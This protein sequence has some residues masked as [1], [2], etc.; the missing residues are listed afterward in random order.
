MIISLNA[1]SKS[2]D[3]RIVDDTGLPVTGLVAATFPTLT[4]SRAGA[5]ADVAFPALSDLALI[6]T[7]YASGGVKERGVGVYRLDVPNAMFTTQGQI[8]IR[9]EATNK[10][11]M[12]PVLDVG[13]IATT[14]VTPTTSQTTDRVVASTITCY[15]DENGWSIGPIITLDDAGD[16]VDLTTFTSLLFTVEDQ[17]ETDLLSTASV[18][19]SGA[20]DNQWTVTGTS[21]ITASAPAT[22]NWSL[23]GIS[24]G[25]NQVLGLG[26]LIV[27]VAASAD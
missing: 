11:V 15:L 7:A 4:Y 23:R 18:T 10:R 1:T 12:V 25:V 17:Y 6:T 22:H 19:I 21:A 27:A 5:N 2:V 20:D 24:T 14:N 3:I 16:P 26:P 13:P 8:T 9:G